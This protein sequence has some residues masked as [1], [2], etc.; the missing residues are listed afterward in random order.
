MG[1][2]CETLVFAVSGS[3]PVAFFVWSAIRLFL[4]GTQATTL[5]H[6]K[7]DN[8]VHGRWFSDYF[9]L[10]HHDVMVTAKVSFLLFTASQHIDYRNLSGAYVTLFIFYPSWKGMMFPID[11]RVFLPWNSWLN[12]WVKSIGFFCVWCEVQCCLTPW[13]SFALFLG[14]PG[15]A[16]IGNSGIWMIWQLGCGRN[17]GHTR[18]HWCL[19]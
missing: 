18:T 11:S 7:S 15:P 2:A 14:L 19:Q 1:S 6:I 12:H 3:Q 17:I 10:D 8:S 9:Q 4:R 13:G 16:D 5:R